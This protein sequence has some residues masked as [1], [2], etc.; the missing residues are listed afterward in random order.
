MINNIS[1]KLISAIGITLFTGVTQAAYQDIAVNGGFESGDF[2]GWTLFPGSAGA[3]GQQISTVNPSS[4]IYSANLTELA[5]AANVIKQANLLPGAWTI[6]QQIDIAFDYRGIAAA[7]AV[8]N[9]EIFTELGGGQEGV[10][11]SV[12][13]FGGPIFP[14]GNPDVWTSKS[15]SY[16]VL[17][18][19]SGGV[20][21]Q[22][23]VACAPI[24]GCNGD[25][26]IDNVSISADVNAVPVPAAVWLFGSGLIGLVGIA[27]KKKAA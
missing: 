1:T 14:N 24:E 13:L 22:F 8:L 2:T 7:G 12:N 15:V 3:A 9:V 11:S 18:E 21:L 6:G 4:G 27:R 25:Y 26:F 17:A 23:S 16:D 20:T 5:P 10:S 19:A